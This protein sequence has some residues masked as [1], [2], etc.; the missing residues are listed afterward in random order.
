MAKVV[1]LVGARPQYVKAAVVSAAFSNSSHHEVL[2]DS[3]QHYDFEMAQV[4]Y[5]QLGIPKPRYALGVGSGSHA[6][7]T[8]RILELFDEVLEKEQPDW[9]IVYGDTNTTIAGGLAAAKRVIP[10]AHIEAGLRSFNRAMPEEINRIATDSISTRLFAPTATAYERLLLEGHPPN[11]VSMVGDVMY[12]AALTFAPI[13][14]SVSRILEEMSITM[15]KYVLATIHRAENTDNPDALASIVTAL[16]EIAKSRT[17]VL[18]LHPRTKKV[19]DAAGHS[20]GDVCVCGPV[21]F[22]DMV[23]LEMSAQVIVT[24]SGG[25]QKEAYFHGV[26]CVTLRRETEWG[27]L[28]DAGWNTLVDPRSADDIVSTVASRIGTTGSPI[29]SYGNGNAADLIVQSFEQ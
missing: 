3:G 21:G 20:L 9:V 11:N 22:L 29:T 12:D 27:E 17:V 25:V 19:L 5:D 15:G 16:K 4:F 14:K 18:P 26:P 1:T 6:G 8:A 2:V 24:D 23:A 13:A 28:V 7:Q 10:I